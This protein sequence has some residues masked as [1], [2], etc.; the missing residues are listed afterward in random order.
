MSEMWK[1]QKKSA[2]FQRRFHLCCVS[3]FRLLCRQVCLE[4]KRT[5]RNISTVHISER[6]SDRLAQLQLLISIVFF[7]RRACQPGSQDA[8]ESTEYYSIFAQDRFLMVSCTYWQHGWFIALTNMFKYFNF[9]ENCAGYLKHSNHEK[10]IHH[11][12]KMHQIFG[13]FE[14]AWRFLLHSLVHTKT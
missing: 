13:T 14:A 9:V 12:C 8:K 10:Y 3:I 1:N 5:F 11:C 7:D 2:R 6:R 4:R